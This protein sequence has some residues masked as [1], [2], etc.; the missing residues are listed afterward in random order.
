M[1]CGISLAILCGGLVSL[2][3]SGAARW[4]CVPIQ[5]INDDRYW[6]T[7]DGKT[8]QTDRV[9]GLKLRQLA[10]LPGISGVPLAN[11][12]KPKRYDCR[13]LRLGFGYYILEV[14]GNIQKPWIR[15]LPR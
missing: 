15:K 12:P 13:V 4:E 7:I 10:C 11:P 2:A 14:E 6:L 3:A 8:V 5:G 9:E 1:S